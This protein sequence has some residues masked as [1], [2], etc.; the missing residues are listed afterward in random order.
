MENRFTRA[1]GIDLP[2]VGGPMYPC[3]NPELVAAVSAAGGIGIIQPVTLTHVC[4]YEFAEGLRVIRRLTDRPVGMNVLIEGGSRRYRRRMEH[5]LDVALEQGIRFFI[6]SLGKPDWVCAR[7]HAAGGLVYHDVT[8]V[9]WAKKG[10]DCGVDGLIAVNNLA[11]GHAG[12]HSAGHLYD[13]LSCFGLPLIR[14]G[15]VGDENEFASALNMGYDGVQIGTRL[16]ATRE[17]TVSADYKQAVVKAR[18]EDIVLSERVTGVPVSLIRTPLIKRQGTRVG[19]ISR[20]LLAWRPTRR[21]LRILLLFNSLHGLKRS[22][23]GGGE[24]WQAGKSVSG[25][26]EVEAV[27]DI[28]QRFAVA[29]GWR[30]S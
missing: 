13:A 7:V 9:H 29:A 22:A 10:I 11:G 16:I 17:C 3:S 6:T 19:P 24:Y 28:V 20:R 8:E 21:L 25:I 15:G 14:A 12:P 1:L 27:A 26:R 18:A 5:W 4:G 23:G 30:E 2:L